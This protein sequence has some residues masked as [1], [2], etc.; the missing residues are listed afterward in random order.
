M[1]FIKGMYDDGLIAPGAF[2]MSEQDK[3]EEFT[4]ARV[5]MMVSSMAHIN[6]IRDRNPDL[7]FA[8]AQQR[9]R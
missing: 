8:I 9:L 5:A 7:N 6:L 1:E 3:V 4:N 2:T